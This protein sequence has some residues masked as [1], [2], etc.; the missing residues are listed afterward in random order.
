MFKA[1][2]GKFKMNYTPTKFFQQ[3]LVCLALLCVAF[4]SE[5]ISRSQFP[6]GFLFGAATSSYQ[7][8]F[9]DRILIEG[10]VLEDGRGLNNWDAFTHL[11]G[12]IDDGQTADVADDHYHHWK[13]DIELLHS[14]GVNAYRFSISWTRILPRGRFGDIN[15]K[16]ILF[17]NQLIDNLLM[18]GIEPFVTLSHH[19]IPQ[20]LEERYNSWLNPQIQEDFAY[21]AEIC[22]KSFGG[23]VKYWAT[24]NE[25]MLFVKFAYMKG[26]YPPG[27]C[28]APFG[29]CSSGNSNT[30]PL[31]AI[32][33]MI[34]SH[35][36][37]TVIYRKLYQ[38]KQGGYIG[39]VVNAIMY[40]PYGDDDVSREAANRA[41]AFN[42]AWFLDP[43]IH[44][45]Y[46]PEMRLYL[47]V[48]L[49]EFSNDQSNKLKDG[50]DFIG[51][52][53]YS[54]F[55]AKDCIQSP[56]DSGNH[57]IEGYTHITGERD[58]ILIGEETAM[59]YMYVVPNGMEKI[60]GYLKRRYNNKPMFVTE[61]GF[62]QKNVPIEQVKEL[63]HDVKRVEF[64][65]SYLAS[66]ARAIE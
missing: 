51:V 7:A 25:P 12:K 19:D 10:A 30:E 46:P 9:L 42:V 43:L 16:G 50:L 23:R 29:N 22:F 48:D 2:E 6:D 59:R 5:E 38:P 13:E 65:K 24:I 53:H 32:H 18:K 56:C 52:N 8:C 61:N 37:A 11:R 33:N 15:P 39:V 55:Y 41:L 1:T 63:I 28:S 20:E 60:I 36:K 62:P 14:L 58:G 21:F 34:L 44:G 66:L 17:Y 31:I 64:H 35:I 47:G 54:S 57:A 26:I 45:E 27:R 3:L 49:P 40:E 4:S